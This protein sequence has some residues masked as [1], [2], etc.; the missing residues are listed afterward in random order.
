MNMESLRLLVD[1]GHRLSFAAVAKD[2]GIDPSSVSRAIGLMEEELGVRLFQRTTRR[3]SLTEGGAVFL[4]R[5]SAILDQFDEAR[6]EARAVSAAPSGTLRMTASVAF[7]ERVVMPLVPAFRA[8]YPG[9]RLELVLSDANVDLVA[10]GIDLAVRLG[11]GVSGD[12][13]SAKFLD[14]RYRVCAAPQYL[15]RAAKLQHPEGLENHR[16]VLFTLP[17]FRSAW[18]FRDQRG[19]ITKVPVAGDLAVSS[20]LSLRSAVV[21]GAGPGLLA[22]WLIDDD[23]AAGHLVDLF[24]GYEVTAT[25]FDTAAWFV[26]PSRAYLPRKVR[27]MIDFLRAE[28]KRTSA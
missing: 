9:V 18:R 10:E 13:V 27:V 21:A 20:A 17:G 4:R 23:L 16:C 24:P 5:L 6:E 19:Q 7:G 14:T 15:A 28:V 25:T 8:A 2:R 22:D 1:V 26:Y 3:M 11:P 12:V